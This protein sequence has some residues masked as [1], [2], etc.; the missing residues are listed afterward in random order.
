[1]QVQCI[2]EGSASL[3]YQV[4]SALLEKFIDKS[5]LAIRTVSRKMQVYSFLAWMFIPCCF[6]SGQ[7]TVVFQPGSTTGGPFPSNALTVTDSGNRTGVQINLP[8]SAEFCNSASNASVCSNTALL[9]Q[10]DGFSVNP[11]VMVCF[12]GDINSATLSGGIKLIPLS[13]PQNVIS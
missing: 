12:S 10:L 7:T 6:L 5:F 11:R 3:S 8:S 13:P 4:V 9:N 1:M 2:K